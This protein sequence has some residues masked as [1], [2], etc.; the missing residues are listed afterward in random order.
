MAYRPHWDTGRSSGFGGGSGLDWRNWSAVKTIVV[1]IVA[2]FIIRMLFSSAQATGPY[3]WLEEVFG[4]HSPFPLRPGSLLFPLQTVTY[5]LLHADFWHL[6]SN[7]LLFFIFAPDL[8]AQ[9]GKVRVL[10]LYVVA[11]VV[12]ALA[13]VT[14]PYL[15][16]A[17]SVGT[18]GASGAV[19]GIIV[20]GALRDP[21]K[22]ILIWGVLPVPALLLVGVYF[23][24]DVAALIGIIGGATSGIAV[25]CHLGGAAIGLVY[26]KKGD[27]VS[28]MLEKRQRASVQ[29]RLDQDE[30]KRREMD[31][32]L[33]KI[34]SDGLNSLSDA[35]RRFLHDRSRDLQSRR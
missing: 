5:T 13:Q 21:R 24:N 2:M 29:K 25:A 30:S 14:L 22:T 35:E 6:F 8:E 34:Q 19:S 3:L 4:L 16:G 7:L 15:I 1:P 32:I 23:F 33:A 10:R 9:M 18:I 12:G 26:W 20:L 17:P 11:A 27:V 28:D 31:R